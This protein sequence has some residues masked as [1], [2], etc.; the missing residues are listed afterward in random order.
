ME[1]QLG[2]VSFVAISVVQ[3]SPSLWVLRP[4]VALS[5]PLPLYSHIIERLDENE[6]RFSSHLPTV[7]FQFLGYCFT[8]YINSPFCNPIH[9][10]IFSPPM[11]LSIGL[12]TPII[13]SFLKRLPKR[14]TTESSAWWPPLHLL[15]WLLSLFP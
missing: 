11:V 12:T 4:S 1:H 2:K 10:N 13:S 14:K 15:F 6:I 3:G 7:S 5:P 9:Y 8:Q